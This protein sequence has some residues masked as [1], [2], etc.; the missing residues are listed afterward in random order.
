MG[1]PCG[2]RATS[3][4]AAADWRLNAGPFLV[5][6]PYP[7]AMMIGFLGWVARRRVAVLAVALVTAVVLQ[8]LLRTI[9]NDHARLFSLAV[10]ILP[11]LALG[12]WSVVLARS[13]HPAKLVARPEVPAFDVP[14]HPGVVLAV[15][16]FTFLVATILSGL[17]RDVAADP[18]LW[19]VGGPVMLFHAGMLAAFWW[20]ALDR[21]GVRLSPDG[22]VDR[23]VFGS[24]FVPWD[25]LTIP[26][27][28]YPHNAQQVT[29]YLAHPKRV[30]RRGLRPGRPT[31]LPAAGVNAEL[32]ARAIHEYANRANLRSAIGT[33]AELE[34]FQALPHIIDL[35]H[36]A[37]P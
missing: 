3:G 5:L 34:R 8:V 2:W 9:E 30:R 10:G 18:N 25:A 33:E 29:L 36:H 12:V 28:A 22:I 4:D 19:V 11:P 26:Y 6:P 13:F 23:Q 16:G 37:R 24:L 14:A 1:P 27:S 15:T 31:L 21:F 35:T 17:V 20:S 7:V 32:L